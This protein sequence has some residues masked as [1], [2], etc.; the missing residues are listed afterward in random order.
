M[1][2][3]TSFNSFSY[4][5]FIGNKYFVIALVNKKPHHFICSKYTKTAG[6]IIITE[7]YFSVMLFLFIAIYFYN[8][9]CNTRNL[10]TS[11]SDFCY[12]KYMAVKKYSLLFS[13]FLYFSYICEE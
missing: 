7:I 8:K 4:F 13:S 11:F 1:E 9:N 6:G 3:L 10:N 5:L 12:Q 2:K